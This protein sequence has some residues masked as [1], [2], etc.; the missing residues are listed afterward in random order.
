MLKN[1]KEIYNMKIFS[2]ESSYFLFI[3]LLVDFILIILS[4]FFTLNYTNNNLLSV[5]Q[6][7]GYAEVFQYIKF[8]LITIILVLLFLQK[9]S[10][11][12]LAWSLLFLYFLIDDSLSLHEHLG[13]LVA[14]YYEYQAFFYLRAQ[15]FGELTISFI[16]GAPIFSFVYLCYLF[17]NI[18]N[19][20]KFSEKLFALVLVL[21]FFGVIVDMLH[22]MIPY[23]K[24]IMGLIED[25]GEMISTSIIAYYLLSTYLSCV[26][27]HQ[28]L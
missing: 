5:E 11:I 17:N 22:I 18:N 21:I 3:L 7:Q 6:D 27:S 14:Q 9:K 12:Y 1:L 16:F 28:K 8:F 13:S 25:G 10:Y 15:D 19:D 23:G 2:K 24:S 4:F 26:S 20:K